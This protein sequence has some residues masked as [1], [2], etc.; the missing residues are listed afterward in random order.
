[1]EESPPRALVVAEVSDL[2]N[3]SMA[4]EGAKKGERAMKVL[5]NW[6]WFVWRQEQTPLLEWIKSGICRGRRK[7][8]SGIWNPEWNGP[9]NPQMSKPK[10]FIN[11][12]DE[13]SYRHLNINCLKV[14]FSGIFSNLI[15]FF[16]VP[17]SE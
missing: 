4:V 14:Y 13:N 2:I 15:S 16:T 11:H 9:R 17:D 10:P 3:S 1:M 5:T 7:C 6:N 8:S 12:A